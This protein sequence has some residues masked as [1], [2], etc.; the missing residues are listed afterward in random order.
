[1]LA[2]SF[3]FSV[4]YSPLTWFSL[5]PLTFGVMI[6]CSGLSLSAGDLLGV[7]TALG[8]TMIFVAQNI[9]SKKLLNASGHGSESGTKDKPIS[10]G[11]KSSGRKL[12]KI[13]ILLYSSGC[14]SV[15]MV[16]LVLYYDAPVM[17]RGAAAGRASLSTIVTLLLCNGV[18]HF[19]QNLL[20]FSV[21]ALVSPVT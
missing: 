8:S 15:L 6:A 5:I 7:V 11:A 12:D 4:T 14:A 3:L 13:N 16:P 17:L 21:L 10:T 9:Y 1:M 18:V 19:A 2:Y 20:A